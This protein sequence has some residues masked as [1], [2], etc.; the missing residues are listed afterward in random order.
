MG[1]KM[2]N[3]AS[4][5]VLV[6]L[7]APALAAGQP[8]EPRP[9][10]GP[11]FF[12]S[13]DSD[14]TEVMR[15]ALDFDLRNRG[16]D[17]YIGVRVEKARFNPNGTGWYSQDRVYLRAADTIGDWQWRARI[18]TDGHTVIGSASVND[19]APMR[20]E[21]FVERDIVE[22]R[23]GLAKGIYSTFAGAA[24]DLPVDDRN[25]FTALA[26]LQTFTGENTRFHLRGS[27]IHVLEPEWGLSAQL[28][29]RYFR[30]SEPGEFDYYSPRWYAEVLPVVQVRRF[31]GGWELVGA[32]GL[33]LQRDSGSDW[34]Q[35][36]FLHARFRSPTGASQWSANG[37]FTYTNTPSVSGTSRSGYRYVQFSLGALRRF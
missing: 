34:R 23:Q 27:Y 3:A 6:G 8:P 16:Q 25:V 29:S 24:V 5:L 10:A 11:E 36:R 14:D 32:G 13:A 1:W 28:R 19:G 35:S 2:K 37:A 31:F 26:G 12:Y 9:A 22:T 17:R 33:G 18:G 7:S 15:A 4:F 21:V 30:S 20:K